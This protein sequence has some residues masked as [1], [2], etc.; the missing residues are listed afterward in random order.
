[1]ASSSVFRR[2]RRSPKDHVHEERFKVVEPR[3]PRRRGR[4]LFVGLVVLLALVW[5]VPILVAHSPLLGWVVGL[6]A[7]DLDGSVAV[8]SASLGWFSAPQA[9]GVKVFDRQGNLVVDLAEAAGER[10]LLGMVANLSNL[11]TFRLEKPTLHVELRPDG[12]NI[13]DLIA[14]YL[15]KP[16]SEPIAVGVEIVDGTVKITDASGKPPW[17]I[18]K[19]NLSFSTKAEASRPMALVASGVVPGEGGESRFE[20]NVALDETN[21]VAIKTDAFALDRLDSLWP[22]LVPGMSLAGRLTSDVKCQWGGPDGK[23]EVRATAKARDLNLADARL[24]ADRFRLAKLDADGGFTWQNGRL[25][26]QQAKADCDVGK[27]DLTG[28]LA[29]GAGESGSWL[30]ALAQQECHLTGQVDLAKLAAMFPQTLHIH[31]QTQVTAGTLA[32]DLAGRRAEQGMAWQGRIE[33]SDLTAL[34][35]GKE[36]VWQQPIVVTL[37]AAQTPQGPEIK[38]LDCKSHFLT[39][40]AAGRRDDLAASLQFD[41]DR[42][43]QR[44]DGF[45]DLSGV[46]MAGNGFADLHWRRDP[47]DQFKLHGTLQIRNLVLTT[48]PGRTWREENALAVVAA[49]GRTTFTPDTRIDSAQ[50]EL[51]AGTER[52]I[53]KLAKPVDRLAAGVAWPL[54]LSTHGDLARW[55]DRVKAWGL[56]DGWQLA[57][58]YAAEAELAASTT[59][60]DVTS[61]T[62]KAEPLRVTG[63]AMQLDE[64]SAELNLAGQYHVGARRALVSRLKLATDTLAVDATEVILGVPANK[65]V[66]LAGRLVYRGDLARLQRLTR[67]PHAPSTWSLAGQLRGEGQLKQVEGQIAGWLDTSV[68][69]IALADRSGQKWTEPKVRLVAC[70]TYDRAAGLLKLDELKLASDTLGASAQ[71]Q[72]ATAAEGAS[73][74]LDGKLDYDIQKLAALA[75][76]YTGTGVQIVGRGSRPFALAGPLALAQARATAAMDWTGAFVYGF[77]VGPGEL[78]LN[79]ASGVLQAEPLDLAVSQGRVQLSPRMR[80]A[81]EPAV[82]EV[83]PGPI[84]QNVRIDPQMCAYGLQYIAPVLAGVA[85]AQGTFSISLDECLIPINNPAAGRLAGRFVVHTVE[86]GPG[87]LVQELALLLTRNPIAKLTRESVIPFR[88]VNGRVHHEGLELVFPEMTIRTKGSVGLDQTLSLVAEMP[89]PPKW[90]GG[91]AVLADALRDQILQVPLRGTLSQPKLDQAR[92]QQYNQQFIRQAAG[93]LLQGELNRQLDRLLPP[94]GQ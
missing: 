56:L 12:S 31:E 54:S 89:I 20:A 24:G 51:R 92:L 25:A 30:D 62:L 37:D 46:Q 17:T 52:L 39:V 5:L 58:M 15:E 23:V 68:D 72:L 85:T 38:N 19:L 45:V 67:D 90:T 4:R 2:R 41:L 10:T 69:Q 35:R 1:M 33:T 8:D 82:L 40:Q 93:N 49:A 26:V 65:P 88:M 87:P 28:T 64:S 34:R 21:Q 80:L 70:G 16:S 57:G 55:N 83:D 77:R 3:R 63:P 91:N 32:F 61:L 22:R 6:A 78:K 94:R 42:L 11:G 84:V 44:L 71:G 9:S 36:L 53:V 47:R 59:T 7:A 79:L 81:P 43:A 29:L 13:E 50:V 76:P 48:S 75:R 18:E 14:K 74:K 27:V 73:T 66:E 60:V 86:V